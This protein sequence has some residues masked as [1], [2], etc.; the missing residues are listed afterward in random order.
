VK[1]SHVEWDKGNLEHFL[2]DNADREISPADAEDVI[3]ASPNPARAVR[4]T[5]EGQEQ[6]VFFGETR[7]GRFLLIATE[8]FGD[9]G[10]RPVT[11]RN[12]TEKEERKYTGWRRTVK[13]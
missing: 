5:Y 3:F 11:A 10:V 4:T 8:P 2:V 6:I 9:G 7:E 1:V 12:M 13:Q